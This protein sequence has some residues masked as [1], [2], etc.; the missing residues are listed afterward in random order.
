MNAP[1]EP[2]IQAVCAPV[3]VD[4]G[5][6]EV[7]ERDCGNVFELEMAWRRNFEVNLLGEL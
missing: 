4:N 1:F 2:H 7:V 5:S 3:C 6:Q